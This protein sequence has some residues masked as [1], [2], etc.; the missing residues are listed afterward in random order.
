[1]PVLQLVPLRHDESR[2]DPYTM[3]LHAILIDIDPQSRTIRDVGMAV[4]DPDRVRRHV[5]AQPRMGQCQCPGDL[6][7]DRR[8]MQ[9]S[10]TRDARLAGLAG[11]VDVHA[12]TVAQTGGLDD[13]AYA[14][15]LDGLEAHA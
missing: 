1:M 6:R 10:S 13:G 12:E 5:I 2:G 3:T 15:Q 9:R 4:V 7:N 11:D 8:D 14:T